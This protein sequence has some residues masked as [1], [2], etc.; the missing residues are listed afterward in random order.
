MTLPRYVNSQTSSNLSISHF[1]FVYLHRFFFVSFAVVSM[2]V[3]WFV[4][5]HGD[6]KADRFVSKM[7][8]SYIF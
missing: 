2:L 8:E 7:V 5:L 6:G 1:C 3:A 4:I